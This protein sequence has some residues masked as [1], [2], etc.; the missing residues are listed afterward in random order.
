MNNSLRDKFFGCFFG[1]IIGDVLGM[2]YEFE[3]AGDFHFDGTMEKGGPF[4]L[5]KGYYTDDT[6]MMLAMANSILQCGGK[7]DSVNQAHRYL[8]WY[9]D[10]KFSSTGNCFDIGHQT[11]LA[12]DYFKEYKEFLTDSV[13][14][15]NG[16]LMRV[17]PTILACL[18]LNT[19][20][21]NAAIKESC[22]NT[23]NSDEAILYTKSYA[24]FVRD[25]IRSDSVVIDN[26]RSITEK[27]PIYN[28]KSND[29]FEAKGYIKNTY[30]AALRSF[31]NTNNYKECMIDI[32][33]IGGDTDTNACIAGMLAGA[34]YGYMHLPSEWLYS[35]HNFDELY[36]TCE[37]LYNLVYKGK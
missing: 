16:C 21:F 25:V 35:I 15:G 7:I 34:Y 33:N 28:N 2:P 13:P 1:A 11:R 37:E 29:A 22:I 27:H 30:Y 20:E 3:E 36:S 5:P 23:H 14:S 8:E 12:L 17:A 10:G 6:S 4:N 9:K 32:I 31:I 26:I 24:H 18:K 19:E